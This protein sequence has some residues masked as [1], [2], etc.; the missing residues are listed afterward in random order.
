MFQKK[1]TR[2]FLSPQQSPN[3]Q[4]VRWSAM[5]A[6]TRRT[7][8]TSVWKLWRHVTWAKIAAWPSFDGAV[9]SGAPNGGWIV[10]SIAQNDL[11]LRFKRFGCLILSTTG[12]TFS[13]R[14]PPSS[15]ARLFLCFSSRYALLGSKWH[16][17]VL[18]Q[19]VVLFEAA[20]WQ[21]EGKSNWKVWQ[22]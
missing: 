11:T 22:N 13:Y 6:K 4:P 9:S 21:D 1:L 12:S 2:E 7:T 19:Q 17:A 16:Q 15:K 18:H 3:Q 14:I 20:L 8:R 5:S 10:L